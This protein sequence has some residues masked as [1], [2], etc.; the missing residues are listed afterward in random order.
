MTRSAFSRTLIDG[1]RESAE[2]RV[3]PLRTAARRAVGVR[4]AG[5]CT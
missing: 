1:D 5:A 2:R 3:R 4:S